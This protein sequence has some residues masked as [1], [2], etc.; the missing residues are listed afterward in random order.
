M[1]RVRKYRH[2]AA[3]FIAHISALK[4]V[5]YILNTNNTTKLGKPLASFHQSSNTN[6]TN[7]TMNKLKYLI[8]IAAVMGALT[9]SAKADLQFLGAV[10]FAGMN[11][12]DNN[13]TQL[14]AF[15]NVDTTGFTLTDNLENLS[16]NQS[17]T[18]TLGEYLVVHYGRGS[19]GQTPGGSWEFFQVFN[20]GMVTVPGKGNGPTNPDQYGHGGISSIRGFV[21]PTGTVPD[22]GTTVMLLGAALGSLGMARRFLKK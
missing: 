7:Y 2:R 16:G 1:D 12:P 19:G 8:A 5:G 3:I 4:L 21:G 22:G 10:P 11:N 13:L 15:L 14:G 6:Y 18:L 20:N 17:L 9:M